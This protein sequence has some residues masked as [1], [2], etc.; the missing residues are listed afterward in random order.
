MRHARGAGHEALELPW[1]HCRLG[2]LSTPTSTAGALRAFHPPQTSLG[3]VFSCSGDGPAVAMAATAPP[4]PAQSAGAA[5]TLPQ[6]QADH[7]GI[8]AAEVYFPTTMVRLGGVGRPPPRP[9]RPQG[10]A[11][12]PYTRLWGRSGLNGR[13]SAAGPA[14]RR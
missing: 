8:L 6:Q 3:S 14:A 7:V 13:P 1:G 2:N 11:R 5:P 12:A 4:T 9:E 10:R